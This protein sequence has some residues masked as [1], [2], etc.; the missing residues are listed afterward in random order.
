MTSTTDCL[1][2]ACR[3]VLLDDSPTTEDSFR[4]S[5]IAEAIAQLILDENG[6]RAIALTG[7]WGSGKST[8]VRL[9]DEKLKESG[10]Q[11]RLVTFDAWAHQGDPLRRTF[12]EQAMSALADW[13]P[14][15]NSWDR[16]L[17][18]LSRR[19]TET[20]TH[21]RPQ[22]SVLGG[23]GAF[24]LLIS[25]AANQLYGVYSKIELKTPP[26]VTR[27]LFA[28][29]ALPLIVASG[30]ILYWF[31]EWL[32]GVKTPLP[33]LIYSSSE[34]S[35]TT[36]T[37]KTPEPTSI[38]FAEAYSE[39]LRDAVGGIDRRVVFVIDNLD[40]IND[41]EAK[42]IWGTLKAFFDTPFH[43]EH[44]YSKVWVLVPFD[45]RAVETFF[46]NKG[47]PALLATSSKRRFKPSS[48]F[49]LLC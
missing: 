48:G 37:S 45:E 33:A 15:I 11:V 28:L 7:A 47:R 5:T 12:I 30:I 29:G 2:A 35:T 42:A 32:R 22:L 21:A 4:H 13:R 10:R 46:G 31:L 25:P 17:A 3:T 18:I 14:A 1:G 24:A 43:S 39:L 27:T 19:W 16:R 44:W 9:L 40:R 38:E 20:V 49:H 36:S 41:D 6:G 8:V 23:L 34:N 26:Y